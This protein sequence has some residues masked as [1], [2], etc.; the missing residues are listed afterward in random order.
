MEELILNNGFNDLYEKSVKIQ[1]ECSDYFV[2]KTDKNNFY[3][4]PFTTQLEYITDHKEVR[5]SF[6]SEHS[7]NQLSTK[8]GIPIRYLKKCL[9]FEHSELVGDN[10]NDWI[11]TYKKDLFIREYLGEIRGILSQKYSV[12]D[13]PDIL[14]IAGEELIND[15]VIKGSFISPERLHLRAVMPEPVFPDDDLYFGVTIDSSDVGRS[16][17]SVKFLIYK[18]VC[19]NGMIVAED[20]GVLYKQR[21]IGLESIDFERELR[22]GIKKLPMVSEKYR[23]NIEQ[24]KKLP[25]KYALDL[26][27]LKG[28]KKYYYDMQKIGINEKNSDT[29]IEFMR[30]KYDNSVWGLSSSISEISQLFSLEKRIVLEEYAGKLIA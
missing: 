16:V 20:S 3:Y 5:K 9:L 18:E 22:E 6:L 1:E 30:E 11:S 21:H 13:T 17:L 25:L 28:D 4:N 15:Y 7:F 23:S 19:T 29:M 8:L 27:N 14:K 10:I 12:L 2:S 24:K 26:A